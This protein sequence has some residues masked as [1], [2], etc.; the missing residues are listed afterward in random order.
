M[1][2]VIM[3]F[4]LIEDFFLAVELRKKMTFKYAWVRLRHIRYEHPYSD[5]LR[6]IDKVCSE[7]HP[8]S[9]N[10]FIFTINIYQCKCGLT[11]IDSGLEFRK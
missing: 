1:N 10:E 2:F 7:K 11:Y 5:K 6:N 8:H 3:F 9:D 4:E